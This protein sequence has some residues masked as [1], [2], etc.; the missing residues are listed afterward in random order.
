MEVAITQSEN[1]FAAFLLGVRK[2]SKGFPYT[3]SLRRQTDDVLIFDDLLALAPCHFNCIPKKYYIPDVRF[4]FARPKESLEL[5]DLMEAECWN[6][7]AP[8]LANPEWRNKL[9]RGGMSDDEIRRK[10]IRSFNFPPSQFQLHIQW[11]VPPLLPFQHFMAESRNHFHEG[12]AIHMEYVR[13]CLALDR[14]LHVDRNTPIDEIFAHFAGHGVVYKE[15]WDKFYQES[16]QAT[17]DV[18]NW[19]CDDFQYVVQDGKVHAFSV[20]E[21]AVQIGA[22]VEGLNAADVQTKDKAVLQNYGRPYTAD[23]KPGSRSTYTK[24]PLRPV[25]GAGGF[26]EWPGVG[27]VSPM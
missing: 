14:P 27:L 7:M 12:R 10:I 5:L 6:A 21:N 19:N 26:G 18:Q 3:M 16:L 2:A 17:M 24:V 20:V 8:F 22:V 1:V 23:G 15:S 13:E 11:I 25:I 4:L 9:Y